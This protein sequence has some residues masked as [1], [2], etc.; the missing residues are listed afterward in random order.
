MT[1]K[2]ARVAPKTKASKSSDL[3]KLTPAEEDL[4]RHLQQG[5]QLQTDSLGANPV[6]RRLKDDQVVRPASI[7]RGTVKALAG[8]GMIAPEKGDDPLTIVWRVPKKQK[9]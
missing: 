8:R 3:T 7:N 4:L 9:K 1:K 5:Y 2:V 6:L